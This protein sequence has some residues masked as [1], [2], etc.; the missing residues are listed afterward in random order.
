MF[1]KKS[2]PQSSQ[3]KTVLIGYLATEQG[4]LWQELLLAQ[5]CQAI[6]VSDEINIV[7]YIEETNLNPDL[8]LVDMGLKNPNS[9]VLQS[10][11]V[12]QWCKENRPEIKVVFTSSK[13]EQILNLESRWALRQGAIAL[14]PKLTGTNLAQA[15]SEVAFILQ[16]K[17]LDK[18]LQEL[19]NT[20][21]ATTPQLESG[22][23]VAA[24]HPVEFYLNQVKSLTT[25]GKFE[26]AKAELSDCIRLHHNSVAAYILRGNVYLNLDQFQRALDD[27]NKAIELEPKNAEVFWR[28]GNMYDKLGENQLALQDFERA[29]KLNPKLGE[30][31]CGRG[32]AKSR[33]GD[34]QG[35]ARDYDKAI[36]CNPQFAE[37]YN[38]RGILRSVLGNVKAA[39]K[40]FDRAI[41]LNPEYTDAYYNRGNIYSDLGEWQKAI[42]DY[43]EAIRLNPGFALAYGNRGIAHYEMDLVIKAIADTTTAS[44]IFREQGDT[45]AY[46]RSMETL[47]QMA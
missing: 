27:Y 15:M 28:R 19:I 46:R 32:L 12:C 24:T 7:K 17:V 44:N 2:M 45:S 25:Q 30:A 34:E 31:Y 10:R 8:I 39:L 4:K 14:L 6:L 5:N 23:Q 1:E 9:T 42:A 43:T 29:I 37:S 21:K 16:I 18:S 3:Q 47:T 38:N 26:E 11:S 41:E 22:T 33:G 20:Q 35:A 40:D 36:Q 13:E